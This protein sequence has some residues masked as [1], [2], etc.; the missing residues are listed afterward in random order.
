M[1]DLAVFVPTISAAATESIMVP[2]W[3]LNAPRAAKASR[4]AAAIYTAADT[5]QR[6]RI[7][8]STIGPRCVVAQ[9]C[10]SVLNR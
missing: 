5:L 2:R 1:A 8:W 9:T 3:H 6:P 4:A 10:A 7:R